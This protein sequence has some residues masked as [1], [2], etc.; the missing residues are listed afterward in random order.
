VTCLPPSGSFFALGTTTV[1]CTATDVANNVTT[2]TFTVTVFPTTQYLLD[3]LKDST[4][5]LVTDPATEQALLATLARV[6]QYLDA[7]NPFLAYLT[8]LQY[9]MQVNQYKNARKLTPSVAGQ[10]LTQAQ[11][12]TRTMI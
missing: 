6:Q 8:T 12:M 1:T 11:Q 9:V 7:G 3:G 5:T 4:A 2:A 10:L